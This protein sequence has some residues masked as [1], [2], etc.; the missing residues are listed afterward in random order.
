M[1][2]PFDSILSSLSTG[3]PPPPYKESAVTLIEEALTPHVAA[4]TLPS[5]ETLNKLIML[6]ELTK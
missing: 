6:H 2:N 3:T 4:G 5:E 1:S